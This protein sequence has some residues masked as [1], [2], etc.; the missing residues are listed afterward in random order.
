MAGNK[1]K[2]NSIKSKK[3]TVGKAADVQNDKNLSSSQAL[4][5]TDVSQSV[6]DGENVKAPSSVRL[7]RRAKVVNADGVKI[8]KVRKSVWFD[9]E[10]TE[11]GKFEERDGAIHHVK[12]GVSCAFLD[13]NDNIISH[14]NDYIATL[15]RFPLAVCLLII[16]IILAVMIAVICT[17]AYFMKKTGAIDYAPELFVIDEYGDNW[18]QEENL[19]IFYN[20]TFGT[21]KIAPGMKGEYAFTLKNENPNSLVFWF[22]FSCENEYGIDLAYTLLRDVIC[23]YGVDNKL[24]AH[25]LS[26]EE[27]T[28]EANSSS[29]FVLEWEW[30]HNDAVDT[31]AGQNGAI[32]T[33][34]INLN[35]QVDYKGD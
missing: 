1:K 22:D 17:G 27:M 16:A 31:V 13:K 3:P 21:D 8:G 18:N 15:R 7:P 12:D 28:I 26:T 9:L 32:Y 24:Y 20:D 34:N 4:S 30:R 35:A 11:N 25:E 19:D 33:L 5:G 6:P 2:N 23:I 10:G 14:S 29:V